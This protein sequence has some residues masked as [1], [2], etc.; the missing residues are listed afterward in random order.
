MIGEDGNETEKEASVGTEEANTGLMRCAWISYTKDEQHLH[1][2]RPSS[3]EAIIR[4][5]CM[6][7]EGEV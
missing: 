3:A 4:R 7:S 2:T 5:S 1:R 6:G